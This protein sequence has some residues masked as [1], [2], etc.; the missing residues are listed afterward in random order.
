MKSHRG[1][2]Y[3]MLRRVIDDACLWRVFFLSGGLYF[4][5][6]CPLDKWIK[7]VQEPG[8]TACPDVCF[9]DEEKEIIMGRAFARLVG[10]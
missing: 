1:D 5:F 2:F 8:I 3:R 7:M 4:N 9:A 10:I 6:I